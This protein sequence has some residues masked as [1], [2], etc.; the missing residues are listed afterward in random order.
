V[1]RSNDVL[2]AFWISA[3]VKAAEKD[4]D[5]IP[6]NTMGTEKF[7][8][9]VSKIFE[10]TH[11][12][13]TYFHSEDKTMFLDGRVLFND[14]TPFELQK[15]RA[16]ETDFG[17]LPYPKLTETQV[18]Y[19]TRIGGC[20]LFFTGKAASKEDLEMTSVVLEAMS[21]ESLK[22]CV[23]AY[24]DLMLKTKLARDIESEEIIDLIFANRV[25]DFVDNLWVSEIRDGPLN[26]MFTSKNNTLIS[27]NESRLSGIFDKKR[28]SMVEAF[29]LL[30]D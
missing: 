17:I 11:E 9:A 15:L 1:S 22:M 28:D 5:D 10:I 23:P 25:F 21:C 13:A 18:E 14:C 4:G 29:S 19:Y 12:N 16:M 27:L 7:L 6:Q 3:G 2:P 20:E 8:N 30:N 24:Y 26:T